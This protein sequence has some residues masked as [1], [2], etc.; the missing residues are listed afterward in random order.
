[1]KEAKSFEIK[2]AILLLSFPL[3]AACA[4]SEE[5]EESLIA[6]IKPS[7]EASLRAEMESSLQA[8][9][10]ASGKYF[11]EKKEEKAKEQAQEEQ[12]RE[13]QAGEEQAQEEQMRSEAEAG[14]GA[15]FPA[16]SDMT[17]RFSASRS[18]KY[19]IEVKEI[20][21]GIRKIYAQTRDGDY[22]DME[23]FT[24]D[25]KGSVIKAI[26]EVQDQT[27][28]LYT[29][30]NQQAYDTLSSIMKKAGY[31]NAYIEFYYGNNE[32]ESG[33]SYSAQAPVAF[34]YMRIDGMEFRYYFD[35]EGNFIRRIDPEGTWDHPDR[36]WFA[37]NIYDIGCYILDKM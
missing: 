29:G 35:D 33:L 5:K 21:E 6:E 4:S 22:T 30:Y 26:M 15:S 1:M 20:I 17:K 9:L 19:K 16:S 23:G 36:D 3:L 32:A 25:G 7:I 13:E 18:A 37:D 14:L 11:S 12:E 27:S 24:Y 31:K 2:L 28:H 34:V 8:S 10:E